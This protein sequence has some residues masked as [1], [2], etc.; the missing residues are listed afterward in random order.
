MSKLRR[1]AIYSE[2]VEWGY[3]VKGWASTTR[4][5]YL[6]RVKTADEWLARERS[7]S[8]L[9]AKP[10]DLEAYLFTFA[11]TARNRNH[12]R[13]ALVAFG[14]FMVWRGW[15]DVNPALGLPKLPTVPPQP[16]PLDGEVVRRLLTIVDA[17]SLMD[18]ALILLYLYG[19]LRKTEARLLEWKDVSPDCR[20]VR[21]LGK[22]SRTR[23]IPLH[24]RAQDALFGWRLEC[25]DPQWVF[26][27]PRH[28]GRAV[29]DTYI[30]LL[31]RELG[32]AVGMN[33]LH[34]HLF[35]HTVATRMLE[36]GAS[37]RD[38]QEFLGHAD[39]KTTAIYTK[40]RP[41]RLE[42]ATDRLDFG[43]G[44]SCTSGVSSMN[45]IAT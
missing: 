24:P 27:S 21:V 20:W 32:G 39:P 19:G 2:F 7:T 9:W 3:D 29:S 35:R 11:G 42:E 8:I 37:L 5:R 45:M 26:P 44:T 10:K 23:D 14:E 43:E 34:P 15:V 28:A 6:R 31:V 25:P 13:Q 40:V 17:L 12:V 30:K 22:G 1:D 38:V 41:A 36:Q 16:K 18:R 33:S 4:Y